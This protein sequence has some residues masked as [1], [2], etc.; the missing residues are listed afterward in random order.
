MRLREKL[1][2]IEAM[3]AVLINRQAVR[4]WYTTHE[5]AQ[6]IGMAEFTVREYCRRGRLNAE[7]RA[8]G[9]GAFRQWVLSHAELERYRRNGLLP[10]GNSA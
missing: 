3:L 1:D 4:E 7:K 10:A 8:S 9:R 2:R 5:Y 6:A